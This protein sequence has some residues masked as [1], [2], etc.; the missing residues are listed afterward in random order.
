MSDTE[1]FYTLLDDPELFESML[2]LPDTEVQENPLNY[3]WLAEQQEADVSLQQLAQRYP[4][5]YTQKMIGNTELIC[6][7]KPGDNP[8]NWKTALAESAVP[9]VVKWSHMYQGSEK[10]SGRGI[11]TL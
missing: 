10:P 7:T 1:S 2:N 8:A 6:Y 5:Q 11:T 9:K 3:G 4:N